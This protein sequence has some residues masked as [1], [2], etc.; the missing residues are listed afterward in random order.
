MDKDNEDFDLKSGQEQNAKTAKP[1]KTDVIRDKGILIRPNETVEIEFKGSKYHKD[2][3]K[4]K[5]HPNIAA[6]LIYVQKVAKLSSDASKEN[7]ARVDEFK[8][9]DESTSKK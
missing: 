7:K 1:L 4:E 5:V 8:P 2:G 6:K 3:T 9:A